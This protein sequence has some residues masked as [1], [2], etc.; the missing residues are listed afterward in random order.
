LERQ[1]E[2]IP[3]NNIEVH[4]IV[5]NTYK[6][7]FEH[8]VV[9]NDNIYTY[10]Y[11]KDCKRKR[12]Q[13][14]NYCYYGHPTER[15]NY[16]YYSKRHTKMLGQESEQNKFIEKMKIGTIITLSKS[17]HENSLAHLTQVIKPLIENRS[18]VLIE[19]SRNNNKE[20]N[21]YMIDEQIKTKSAIK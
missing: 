8:F 6:E 17:N 12:H 1:I 14:Y 16:E 21:Y 3:G 11:Y 19:K 18:F 2:I 7:E 5:N 9:Y 13:G 10:D 15:F 20:R 4:Q